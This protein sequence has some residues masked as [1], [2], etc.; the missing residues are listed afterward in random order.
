MMWQRDDIFPL[1]EAI[2]EDLNIQVFKP[3][4]LTLEFQTEMSDAETQDE[5]DRAKAYQIYVD[6]GIKPSVAAQMVGIELPD[7]VEYDMLDEMAEEREKKDLE[8]EQRDRDTQMELQAAKNP[9]EPQP[10]PKP[11]AKWLPS[12]DEFKELSVWRDVALRRLKKGDSLDFTYEPHYGGLPDNIAETIIAELT[13]ATSAEEVKA[14]FDVDFETE[15]VTPAPVY[16]SD[17]GIIEL[18]KSLNALTD[19]YV[20]SLQTT[21]APQPNINVTLPPITMTA[22]LPEQKEASI[23]FSPNIQPAPVTVENIVNVPEQPA[24]VNEITVQPA[25]VKLSMPKPKKEKQRIKRDKS[26]GLI[27]STE[28]EIEY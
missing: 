27:E 15:T 21:P 18:A 25:D 1:V 24:P 13:R 4:G 20:K 28:T 3:L 10:A 9:P 11:A 8:K 26:T 16:K 6:A 23:T 2:A 17:P 5:V 7:G 14:A 22:N 19:A 12:V